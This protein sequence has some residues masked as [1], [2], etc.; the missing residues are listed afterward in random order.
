MPHDV[1]KRYNDFLVSLADDLDIPPSTY[2]RIV[3]SYNAVGEWLNSG[4]YE[5]SIDGVS[6]YPQGSIALGTATKPFKRLNKKGYDIDLVCLLSILKSKTTPDYIKKVIGERLRDHQLYQ[7]MLDDEGKRCW[8]LEYTEDEAGNEFHLDVLPSVGES[9]EM[10]ELLREHT[11][12][13][14]LVDTSI[15]ITNKNTDGSY[16]WSTSNPLGYCEWFN[17]INNTTLQA[18]SAN[19]RQKLYENN[20]TLFASVEEVPNQLIRTPLQRAIQILKRHR[21][22]RFSGHANEEFKPISII[23]TTLAAHLY[24]NEGDVYS[25]LTNIATKLQIYS[26]LI[27]R[28]APIVEEKL[29]LRNADGTWYIGNPVNK[30]ENFADRWHEDNDARARAFFE[31]VHWVSADLIEIVRKGDYDE[32]VGSVKQRLE[33]RPNKSDTLE[34]IPAAAP[35][36]IKP[37]IDIEKPNKA[38]S[39]LDSKCLK[40]L[41]NI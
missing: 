36:I 3:Q 37:H 4:E 1:L 31:W 18:I 15:A 22:I 17:K 12:H 30:L 20:K 29:I 6:V 19:A 34:K 24:G 40:K 5:G 23:I 9:A 14:G 41:K 2:L 13:M 38:W 39:E 27:E 32:I 11:D 26:T 28:R 25:A 10:I 35:P 7:K 16:R 33:E 21:D 8:T